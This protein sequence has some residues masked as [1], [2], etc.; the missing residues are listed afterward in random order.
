MGWSNILYSTPTN[1]YIVEDFLVWPQWEKMCLILQRFEAL[2]R[3]K[4]W[5]WEEHPLGD[6]GTE[7][8]GEELWKGGLGRGQ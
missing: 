7:E 6:R 4:A 8:C 1:T 2:G 5:G 3:G